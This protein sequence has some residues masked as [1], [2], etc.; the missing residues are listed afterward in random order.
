MP[1]EKEGALGHFKQGAAG[2]KFINCDAKLALSC[3]SWQLGK[4]RNG[5]V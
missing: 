2:R 1:K 5:P 4:Q 3:S